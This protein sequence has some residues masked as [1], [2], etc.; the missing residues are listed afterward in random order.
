MCYSVRR[1]QAEAPC[2]HIKVLRGK[3]SGVEETKVQR[4]AKSNKDENM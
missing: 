3:L 1:I 4:Q 2:G